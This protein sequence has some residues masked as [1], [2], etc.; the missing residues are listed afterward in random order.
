MIQ[1]RVER[2]FVPSG[3]SLRTALEVLNRE[4]LGVVFVVNDARVMIGLLTDGDVRRCVL[5]GA[6][7]NE[8]IDSFMNRNFISANVSTPRDEVIGL[9]THKIRHV[10]VLDDDGRAND[11]VLWSNISRLAVMQ[12]ALAGNELEYVTDCVRSGWISSQGSYVRRFE[13]M[14]GAFIGTPH[15]LCTS[16]GTA[17]LHLA[18][19]AL[20]VGPGDEVVVPALTFGACA[21]VVIQSGATPVFA[22][23]D[24]NT[25]TLTTDALLEVLTPRTRAVMPV[26]LYGHPCDMDPILKVARA[27][28]L[29]VIEDCAEALG[30]EYKGQKAGTFGDVAAFSFF[31]NKVITTG[32]GGMVV[33]HDAELAQRIAVLRDHGM[34]KDRRYWHEFAGFNYRMTNMQAAVGV[35]QLERIGKFLSHRD[36]VVAR[37]DERLSK[38]P[39]IVLPPRANWCR[40]IFWLYSILVDPELA[41]LGRDQLASRLVDYGIETRPFFHPLHLQPAYPRRAADS[42]PVTLRLA[43]MGLSLPT[44]NDLLLSEVDRVCAA[45]EATIQGHR[46]SEAAQR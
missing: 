37:Y 19:V 16:S 36:A 4:A 34:S 20:G 33:T 17:A 42:L 25:W 32:E 31:A 28:N 45:I 1:S 39:G 3:S 43:S 8:A 35:G 27:Q 23:V 5:A 12:P 24:P 14:F 10:P 9:L 6:S 18:L 29:L 22:D 13:E 26:H 2:I 38:V 11:V 21:N 30:A 44:S 40:N 46:L 41:C 7:L 15:A